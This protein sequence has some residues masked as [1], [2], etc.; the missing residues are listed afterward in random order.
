MQKSLVKLEAEHMA[1]AGLIIRTAGCGIGI[2]LFAADPEGVY[3][4]LTADGYSRILSLVKSGRINALLFTHEHPDH[5]DAGMTV[6]AAEA[7][8]E[9]GRSLGILTT[10]AAARLLVREGLHPSEITVVP[11]EQEN[12]KVPGPGTGVSGE[13]ASGFHSY[14]IRGEGTIAQADEYASGMNGTEAEPDSFGPDCEDSFVVTAFYA[15][16]D[17]AGYRDVRNLVFLIRWAGRKIIIPGDAKP[18]AALF[19]K[20]ADW[21][22]EADWMFS[23]FPYLAK[24]SVRRLIAGRLHVL[25]PVLMHFPVPEKDEQNWIGKTRETCSAAADQLPK[26][27]Y[28]QTQGEAVLL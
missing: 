25:H 21:E 7:A 2:D 1:N 19:E 4:D 12:G 14:M 22:K 20:I 8:K 17:G 6:R 23:P 11:D 28:L 3:P 5:F 10:P 16:H 26:P 15:V 18:D 9:S 24:R 27:L 13:S